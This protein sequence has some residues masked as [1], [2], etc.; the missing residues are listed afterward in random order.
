M[1][2][3]ENTKISL[4]YTTYKY[5]LEAYYLV[6]ISEINNQAIIL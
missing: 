3:A 2:I 6:V 4:V 1:F 5:N